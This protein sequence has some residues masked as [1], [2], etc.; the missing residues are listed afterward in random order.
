VISNYIGLN[1][2]NKTISCCVK[3]ASDQA[4]REAGSEQRDVGSLREDSASI[5]G[6]WPWRQRFSLAGSTVICFRM[7][8]GNQHHGASPGSALV[9]SGLPIHLAQLLTY[10]KLSSLSLG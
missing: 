7:R 2:Y 4:L 10:Q 9:L 3:N 8:T 5:P 6:Q 1:V